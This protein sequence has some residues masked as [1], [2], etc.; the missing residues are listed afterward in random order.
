MTPAEKTLNFLVTPLYWPLTQFS[1]PFPAALLAG[2]L[3]A[4]AFGLLTGF[5]GFRVRGD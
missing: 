5:P 1:L 4:V 2:G 3:V